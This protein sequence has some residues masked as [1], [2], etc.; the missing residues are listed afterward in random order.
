M[1]SKLYI[2]IGLIVSVLIISIGGT[3]AWFSTRINGT[4]AQKQLSQMNLN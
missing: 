1:K 4:G 2:I 3:Y